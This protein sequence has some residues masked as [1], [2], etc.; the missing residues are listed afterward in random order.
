MEEHQDHLLVDGIVVEVVVPILDLLKEKVEDQVDHMLVVVMVV[1]I[2][3]TRPHLQVEHSAPEVV[4]EEVMQMVLMV[5]Q[6][7]L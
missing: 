4:E 2:L 6:V 5:D 7:L 3:L 1:Q